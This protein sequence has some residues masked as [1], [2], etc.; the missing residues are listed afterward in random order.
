MKPFLE[1]TDEELEKSALEKIQGAFV[2]SQLAIE[3]FKKHDEGK[4]STL[5]FS[6]ATAAL[7]GSAKVGLFAAA[8]FGIR[9]LSQ[10]L[11][12]EFQPTGIHVSHV[13]IDGKCRLSSR[14][15]SRVVLHLTRG[16]AGMIETPQVKAAQGTERSAAKGYKLDPDDIAKVGP[17]HYLKTGLLIDCSSSRM[18]TLRSSVRVRGLKSSTCGAY[19]AYPEAVT[20]GRLQ[21]GTREMVTGRVV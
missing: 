3:A 16:S 1:S 11:A 6:G 18:Y 13:V 19:G 5:I 17:I 12:R 7:R 14:M 15:T 21:S 9:A 20:D 8:S 10:S 4:G 2:F